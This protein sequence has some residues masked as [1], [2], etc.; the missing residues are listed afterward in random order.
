MEEDELGVVIGIERTEPLQISI[1][2]ADNGY[3]IQSDLGLKVATTLR[4]MLRAVAGM[5]RDD[6]RD[7][8]EAMLKAFE[9]EDVKHE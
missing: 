3:V 1:T 6:E 7:L 5:I 8:R 9:Q 4:G 2:C